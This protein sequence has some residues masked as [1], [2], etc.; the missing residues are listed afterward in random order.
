MKI[1]HISTEF[2]PIAKAG[3]LGDVLVGLVRKLTQLGHDVAV[4]LP[5]YDFI[6]HNLLPHLQI[7]LPSFPCS[8]NGVTYT[9]RMWSSQ[10]EN[11]RLLLLETDHPKQFFQRGHIYGSEDDTTRFLYF[12]KACIEYL[13]FQNK[14]IDILHL[15]DWHTATAAVLTKAFHLPVRS[16][17]L[18]IHNAE[19]QGRCASWDLD[20]IGLK[21]RDY[22][23]PDQMQDDE[24]PDAI[25]LLKGGIVYAD[26]VNTVS[27]TYAKEILTPAIGGALSATFR[28]YKHKI[29]GI[30][31]GIDQTIWNPATDKNLIIGYSSQEGPEAILKAKESA[32]NQLCKQFEIDPHPRPWMGAI[33]RIVPQKGPELIEQGLHQ[34]LERGGSFFL[35]GSSPIP[36]LQDHFNHLKKKYAGHKNV[37]LCFEYNEVLAHQLYAALDFLL[38]PSHFE[39]CGLS[40]LIAMRYGTIPIVRKTGGLQDTVF[41]L[42]NSNTTLGNRNGFVFEKA[43]KADLTNA[44][45]RAMNLFLKNPSEFQAM[46]QRVMRQDFSWDKPAKKYIELYTATF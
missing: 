39:P 14:P 20:A 26:V 37:F 40:Q 15:H 5:K 1:I 44:I 34:T 29:S 36:S 11:C 3:G 2:A 18:S 9:N 21:G 12:S 19:Y 32:R 17:V 7:E 45:Q 6:S 22:L 4:I 16:V 10:V 35:L 41:D 24:Y 38:M 25:N 42:E 46:V 30:L 8:E 43:T 31:N 33:T 13:K 23:N 27:P 28:K